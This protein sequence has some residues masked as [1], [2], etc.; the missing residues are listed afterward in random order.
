MENTQSA[1]GEARRAPPAC[2][3]CTGRRRAGEKKPRRGATDERPETAPTNAQC[4][5]DSGNVR[6]RSRVDR[7]AR[8]RPERLR[9]SNTATT[10]ALRAPT[11]SPQRRAALRTRRYPPC[12][13]LRR[14]ARARNDM[15][16]DESPNDPSRLQLAHARLRSCGREAGIASAKVAEPYGGR[17]VLVAVI[18]TG[19][20]ADTKEPPDLR[21]GA[22]G[23][24]DSSVIV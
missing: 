3:K 6:P 11:G 10:P 21:P 4:S 16:I 2:V 18:S 17:W 19:I 24:Q 9:R 7:E 20:G 14:R 13:R 15:R 23:R 8:V 22:P 1:G 5:D 12:S